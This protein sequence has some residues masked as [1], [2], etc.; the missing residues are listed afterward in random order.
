M[1]SFSKRQQNFVKYI[2]AL[3]IPIGI[4]IVI[5]FNNN[6]KQF[7]DT[8]DFV[9][10]NKLEKNNVVYPFKSDKGYIAVIPAH[11]EEKDI[12]ITRH[13][14]ERNERSW[15]ELS[16]SYGKKILVYGDSMSFYKSNITTIFI[17]TESGNMY[18]V[19]SSKDKSVSESGRICVVDPSGRKDYDGILA[20]IKGRGNYTWTK[21]K[22]PYNIKLAEKAKLISLKKSK[23]FCLLSQPDD[24]TGLRNYLTYKTAEKL[25]IPNSIKCDFV[26]LYLNG[27]YSGVYLLTNKIDISNSG[28]S[29]NNLQKQTEKANEKTLKKYKPFIENKNGTKIKG[30][31][32][33]CNPKDITGGYLLEMEYRGLGFGNSGF[34]MSHGGSLLLKSPEFASQEQVEYIQSK[35]FDLE[36]SILRSTG[37]GTG[38]YKPLKELLDYRSFIFNYLCQEVFLN[39]DAGTCSFFVYKNSD[40]IDSRFYAGPIWDMDNSLNNKNGHLPCRECTDILYAAGGISEDENGYNG[41]F[42][43]LYQV[44]EFRATLSKLYRE[45][46]KP[47]ADSVFHGSYYDSIMVTLESEM[48]M[49]NTRWNKSNDWKDDCHQMNEWLR[50][51]IEFLDRLWEQDTDSCYNIVSL[52]HGLIGGHIVKYYVPQNQRFQFDF[53]ILPDTVVKD[54]GTILVFRG[55][56]DVSNRGKFSKDEPVCKNLNIQADYEKNGMRRKMDI[57]IEKII[58]HIGS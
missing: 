14:G 44:P 51:R 5:L 21:R 2:L 22:K 6:K 55:W 12:F 17:D 11:W 34:E 33:P 30:V 54:D 39:T 7:Y 15:V 32:I 24:D 52:K 13:Q 47:I 41:I 37:R 40:T 23:D 28:V 36:H 43:M 46:F 20:K 3:S 45:E 38:K 31:K 19:D 58:S 27:Q 1:M 50:K 42:G 10:T 16:C 4:I 9:I 48:E 29:I 53:P 57:I 56:I 25:G 35:W 8:G 26:N 49:N 18:K